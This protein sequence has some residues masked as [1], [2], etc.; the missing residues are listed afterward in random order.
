MTDK[1]ISIDIIKEISNQLQQ[2]YGHAA[3][4]I[5]P[6]VLHAIS[7]KSIFE[8]LASIATFLSMLALFKF[9]W[10][11]FLSRERSEGTGYTDFEMQTMFGC[12]ALAIISFL[13][14]FFVYCSVAELVY[15]FSPEAKIIFSILD[16]L[17]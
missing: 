5:L 7:I 13:T 8:F 11:P 3:S 14:P 9:A 17:K 10:L 6:I 4:E 2:L 16:G 1:N 15:I 12:M